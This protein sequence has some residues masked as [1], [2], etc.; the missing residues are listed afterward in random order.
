M[1]YKSTTRDVIFLTRS[2][3]DIGAAFEYQLKSCW[4]NNC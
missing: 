2:H 4:Q 3:G 1:L